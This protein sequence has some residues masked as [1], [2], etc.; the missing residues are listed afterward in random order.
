MSRKK[1]DRKERLRRMIRLICGIAALFCLGYFVYYIYMSDSSSSDFKKL[2]DIKDNED[3][4]TVV[5]APQGSVSVTLDKQEPPPEILEEFNALYLKNR[6]I[7]GWI[8]IDGTDIDY[9]VMQSANEE[10]Y[11]DH[12]FDQEKDKN[13]SL[14]ID[15]DCSI[16]P[17]SQNIIIYGHN[18]KSGKMFGTLDKYKNRSFYEKHPEITFDTLYEKGTYRVMYVF[19]DV[20]HEESEVAFKYYQFIDANSMQEYKSNMDEMAAM[21]LYE[22]GVESYYGDSLITLSTCDYSQDAERFVVVA[23]KID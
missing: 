18:M 13:G 3:L 19:N 20:V 10:Y 15:K 7:V 8:R 21:S 4:R 22:T 5:K 11:L 2:S 1:P 9:P 16:W 14:F 23:K 12:N 6:S 17:R